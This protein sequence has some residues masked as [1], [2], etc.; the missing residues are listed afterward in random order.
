MKA[1]VIYL[2]IVFKYKNLKQTILKSMQL[3]YMLETF[4]KIS[5]LTARRELD[6][7]DMFI[8]LRACDGFTQPIFLQK[9]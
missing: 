6:F 2:L 5:W 8:S 7:M 4:Q 3:Y 1:T 9:V